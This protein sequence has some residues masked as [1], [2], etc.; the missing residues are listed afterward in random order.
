MTNTQF[1][2]ESLEEQISKL[3]VEND[4]L[5]REN[6]EFLVKETGLI[7][8]IVE[9]E[10]SAKENAE[11]TNLRDT[12]LNARISNLE[13]K[14]LQ[15]N[16]EKSDLIVLQKPISLEDKEIDEFLDSRYKEQV[17]KEII[18]SIKEKKLQDQNLSS[19]RDVTSLQGNNNSSD[20]SNLSCDTL[21]RKQS[22]LKTITLETNLK[23]STERHEVLCSAKIPY[24]QKVE[25]GLKLELFICAKD[26]NHKISKV[27]DIQI[28]EF[29]LEAIL[30]GSTYENRVSD[31]KSVNNIDDQSARTIVYNE[32]KSLLP[33]ITDVNL[34]K[35]T[36]RAKKV[37]ILYEGIGID[38]ISQITY[39][40]SAISSLKDIQIQNIINDFSKKSTDMS[41][42]KV[43]GV[44]NWN[45]HMS[46]LSSLT[47][48]SAE[49]TQSKLSEIEISEEAKKTLPEIEATHDHGSLYP[50]CKL[51][52]EDG[53]SVKAY[54]E[55]M[56]L[57]ALT[58]KYLDWYA[59]LVEP[60]SSLT[61]KIHCI[62]KISKFPEKKDLI[63]KT[64]H[65]HFPFLTYTNSNA[66]HRDVF[67]YIDSEAKCPICK[68]I[69]TRY[70]IW[71]DWSDLGK[72][73][74]YYLNCSFRIDQKK[75]IIAVQSL[76]ETEGRIPNKI[77]L[78]Q[79]ETS[80][81]QYAIEHKMDSEKF[82]VITE[83]EKKRLVGEELL[84][85][86]IL[87]S[88]LSTTWLDDLMEEWEKTY[89]QFVQIFN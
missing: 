39:S 75:I 3:V 74:H 49:L 16:K 40:A 66:W 62:I 85:R 28:P 68:E 32:I 23:D 8:R 76:P 56:T 10:R 53:K 86:G 15:N 87:K 11:N 18:Q 50:V 27:F 6:A 84:R 13:Q 19:D 21:C 79:L 61:D 65:K 71:G 88:G 69:Y 25:Q 72:D 41:C 45:T 44:S 47:D 54:F 48:S 82:S 83:A 36:H 63:I 14:Q 77:R 73:D 29:S 80:L 57:R 24:N 4:K 17:S 55:E 26:N 5:R 52:H 78:Y 42:Q 64:V 12:E 34:C 43:I 70:C 58:P 51:N 35:I 60:S 67:K 46:D 89:N 30:S 1:K 20:Q 33:D 7:A 31:I 59:K 2:I 9:L 81:R 22:S 37:Y 38:K